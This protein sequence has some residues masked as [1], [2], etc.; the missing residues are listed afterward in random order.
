MHWSHTTNHYLCSIVEKETGHK[1]EQS[2]HSYHYDAS[3][4]VLVGKSSVNL[5]AKQCQ[6]VR[7]QAYSPI[8]LWLK[9]SDSSCG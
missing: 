3:N 7:N 2:V 9:A 1:G 8:H 4:A 6:T 5:G